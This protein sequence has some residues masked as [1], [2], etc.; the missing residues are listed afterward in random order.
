MNNLNIN[1][2]K[3]DD[4]LLKWDENSN[5]RKIYYS[6]IK[7]TLKILKRDNL[8]PLHLS[9]KL[10]DLNWNIDSMSKVGNND[11]GSFL[12]NQALAFSNIQIIKSESP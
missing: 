4:I 3:I 5:L 11:D 2:K 1:L 10:N 9:S 6:E 8:I 12:D 7:D